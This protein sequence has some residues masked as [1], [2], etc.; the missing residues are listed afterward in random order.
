L[1]CDHFGPR[2]HQR[3]ARPRARVRSFHRHDEE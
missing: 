1:H 3:A 2:W